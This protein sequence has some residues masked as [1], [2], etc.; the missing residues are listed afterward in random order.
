MGWELSSTSS[1][2]ALARSL[3]LLSALASTVMHG[4]LTVHIYTG[5]LGLSKH[6][7]VLELLVRLCCHR[8]FLLEPLLVARPERQEIDV[9]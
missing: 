4:Y 2:L 9:M 8:G 7:I 3:Q 6:M 1:W 5:K